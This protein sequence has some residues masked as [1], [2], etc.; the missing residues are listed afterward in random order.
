MVH[1]SSNSCGE[2][3]SQ[4]NISSWT[5]AV[6]ISAMSGGVDLNSVHAPSNNKSQKLCRRLRR[7][8]A[9]TVEFALV[10]PIIFFVVLA[11][12]QFTGL[13]MSQNVLTAAAREGGRVASMPSTV[14][15]GTVVAA[16]QDRLSRGGLDPTLV[17]VNVITATPW[18]DLDTGDEVSVSVS[19]AMS[20]MPWIGPVSI[21]PNTMMS[22]EITYERE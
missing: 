9:A 21:I 13:I 22:A 10:S 11:S 3:C 14:S 19:G 20:D 7:K 6:T 1:R 16:V 15:T 17:T 12:I 4:R 5:A 8:G 2:G 18:V